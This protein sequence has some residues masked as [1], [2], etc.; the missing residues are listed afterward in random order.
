MAYWIFKVAQPSLYPDV[1]GRTYV[2]DN[3]HSVRVR[4]GD[5]FLYLEKTRSRYALSGAGRVA[6]VT[7]QR[8]RQ[9]DRHNA[10]VDQVFTAHLE[11]VIW[12]APPLDIA[13]R[14]KSGTANRR[15]L[16]LPTD[17][18][19]IGWSISIPRLEREQFSSLLDAA[20]EC[21]SQETASLR[22]DEWR[23]DDAW[24]L[25]RKRQR[26]HRFRDAVLNRHN[27]T[28]V[29]CGSRFVPALDIAHIESYA[30]NQ[31]NRA[32]PANGI[33]LCRFCHA[34]FDAHQITIAP[35]GAVTIENDAEDT[36]AQLHFTAVPQKIRRSWLVGVD[37]SLLLKHAEFVGVAFDS[38]PIR[39]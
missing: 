30:S 1:P 17:L 12:F 11:D 23:I 26:L 36:I 8:A 34:A 33:C 21:D 28:C 5:E 4:N 3:T 37:P 31:N 24:S 20:L 14:S 32:N 16:G 29:V 10:R 18:N 6:R 22:P 2:F 9:S 15:R 27:Y 39:H 19:A 25:V 7:A 35:S 38:I 13:G